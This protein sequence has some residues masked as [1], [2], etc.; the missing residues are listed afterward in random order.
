MTD[1]L[2]DLMVNAALEA[3]AAIME[4]YASPFGSVEKSDGSPV[5]LADEHAEKIILNGLAETGLPVLA[6][7]SAAAGN[8]PELGDR[9][10][11]VDPLDG[12]KEF[13]KRNGQFTVNI[14]LV[15]KGRPVTGVVYAPALD[16]LFS[17]GPDGAYEFIAKDGKADAGHRIEVDREGPMHIV[18]S[19]SHGHAALGPL[20]DDLGAADNVS[21]GSSLKFCLLA[22]GD[23]Q[24]Y[25]RFTPTCEWDTAAGQAVLEA[26]GGSV[27][28]ISGVPLAYGKS[29]GRFYNP[30]FAAAVD[31]KLAKR[32]AA[33]MRELVGTEGDVK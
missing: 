5:T 20:C 23:A 6:E 26:A 22:R 30:Y 24:L 14:A 2:L 27:F 16:Q 11:V 29:E 7:E 25:P 8:I 33:K 1:R 10:F 3:G 18:A 12:T 21:V 15:D 31:A 19:L 9:F 13:I 17:G 4:V 32:T 28:A